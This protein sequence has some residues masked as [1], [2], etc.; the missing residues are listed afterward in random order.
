M[1]NT[2]P[3]NPRPADPGRNALLA[4]LMVVGAG[5]LGSV[6]TTPNIPTW[7]AGLEKPAF[8]PPN[9]VFAPVWTVLYAM[10]GL[11][12]WRILA[13]V[14]T[15]RDRRN[16][17]LAFSIQLAL[18][19]VWSFAFFALQSPAAGLIVILLLLLAIAATVRAFMNVD[20]LSGWLLVPYAAWVCYATALNASIWWLNA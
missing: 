12:A 15:G 7:Y 11:A 3:L 8:T 4:G 16:A 5:F 6:A 10:M 20:P 14:Q 2:P 1:R 18:N 17:I 19:T 13:L 9:W